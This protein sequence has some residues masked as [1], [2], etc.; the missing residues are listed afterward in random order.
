MRRDCGNRE[1]TSPMK[2]LF[3]LAITAAGI[4]GFAACGF[5]QSPAVA[6]KPPAK[7]AASPAAP[8]APVSSV[9]QA[10]T[11]AYGDWLLRCE[12]VGEPEKEQRQC[13]IAQTLQ[14]QGQG[15]VA[16]IALSR[17]AV[18]GQFHVVA[19]LP[20][21]V[22][23][24]S[25]VH[26]AIDDKDLQPVELAWRR[27]LT[28]ACLSEGDVKDDTLKRWR[29]LAERGEIRWKN[30]GDQEIV[31]PFSFRGFGQAADAL[32]KQ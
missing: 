27:C 22:A 7:A 31:L 29:P 17:G 5:A 30:G 6:P 23:F 28:G 24:P 2:I 3:R 9:P 11:A 32:L 21:N 15:A 18:A 25:S 16:Q 19:L 8:P 26:L 12:R 14:L 10:T 20:V 1:R 13:E 4:A